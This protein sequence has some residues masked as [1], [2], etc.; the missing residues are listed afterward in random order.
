[1]LLCCDKA[2]DVVAVVEEEAGFIPAVSADFVDVG[3]D[4]PA[5]NPLSAVLGA[6]VTADFASVTAL[7]LSAAGTLG[8][9]GV[10]VGVSEAD[11]PAS[12]A[13]IPS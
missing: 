10:T 11:I 2:A 4:A 13:S 12:S 3:A 8:A 7:Y 5:K 9:D 1:M 6:V